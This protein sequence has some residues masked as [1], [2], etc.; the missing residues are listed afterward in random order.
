MNKKKAILFMLVSA[1]GFA[2][3]QS[4]IK[5]SGNLP[6]YE[7]VFFRNLIALFI[8]YFACKKQKSRLFGTTKTWKFLLS[9][10]LLGGT[11][12]VLYFYAI[13][14]LTLADS[15]ILN[16]LS[17]FF[18]TIFAIIF[19]QEKMAKIQIFALV[20]IFFAAILVIKPRFN[21]S[22]FPAL[23]GFASAIFAGAAYTIVRFLGDKERP[24][25][26]VF[27]FSFVTTLLMIIPMLNR[28]IPPNTDQLIYLS[29]AGFF[30]AIGQFGLT[31][32][33]RLAP[34]N[35]VAIYNYTNIIFAAVIGYFI[36]GEIPDYLSIIGGILIIVTS[37][38][39]YFY[40]MQRSKRSTTI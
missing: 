30:A 38:V 20:I 14:H 28:F 26:I 4:L 24:E 12:M 29:T 31:Y 7:K 15:S 22:V 27:F 34:A 40:Y 18:V 21:L 19:L 5:L 16:K 37:V 23:A 33:Y 36:W 2:V 39:L 35:E 9:R 1:A 17:P 11:G 13:S 6:V 32:A 8:A 25:T 3:M 10:S